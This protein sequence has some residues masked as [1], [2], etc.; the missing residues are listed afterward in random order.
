[1][2]LFYHLL[3]I[4]SEENI[5]LSQLIEMIFVLYLKVLIDTLEDV[6]W[7]SYCPGFKVSYILA[8][9]VGCTATAAAVR[10]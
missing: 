8:L 5:N 4:D 9:A 1:M 2:A 10:A 3:A 7:Q 6:N